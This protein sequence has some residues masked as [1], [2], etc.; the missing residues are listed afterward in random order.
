MS[1][2]TEE[3]PDL[4]PEEIQAAMENFEK[5]QEEKPGT[6]NEELVLKAKKL[7]EEQQ[8]MQSEFKDFVAGLPKRARR[9][10]F[11]QKKFA[12]QLM[13]KFRSARVTNQKHK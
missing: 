11:P 13:S 6:T 5:Y 2:N 1:D 4:T 3:F 10:L 8:K 12:N 9:N 7:A